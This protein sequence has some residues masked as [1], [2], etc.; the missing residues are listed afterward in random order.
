MDCDHRQIDV[1]TVA[2]R[3]AAAG[4][5][6]ASFLVNSPITIIPVV[7]SAEPNI[8]IPSIVSL[9]SE[10]LSDYIIAFLSRYVNIFKYA[11]KMQRG[12]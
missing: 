11:I 6:K 3:P 10:S 8:I 5:K 1:T 2:A 7:K 12:E 4:Q 9:S